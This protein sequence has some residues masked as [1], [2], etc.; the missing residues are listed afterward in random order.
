MSDDRN[1]N[2][3]TH[4][5]PTRVE[6]R[7]CAADKAVGRRRH[8]VVDALPLIGSKNERRQTQLRAS[9]LLWRLPTVTTDRDVNTIKT[10]ESVDKTRTG[11]K[12]IVAGRANELAPTPINI[13]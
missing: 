9:R 11:A 1:N 6:I 13:V 5:R 3:E 2:A 7:D 10:K 4:L 12:Q 8:G